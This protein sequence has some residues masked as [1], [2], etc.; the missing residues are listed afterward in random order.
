MNKLEAKLTV[1]IYSFGKTS[2]VYLSGHKENEIITLDNYDLSF[3]IIEINNDYIII[4]FEKDNKRFEITKNKILLKREIK[5][6]DTLNNNSY[7]YIRLDSI[8]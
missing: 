4:G 1:I 8:N 5:L 6:V 2:T 7:I 3:K